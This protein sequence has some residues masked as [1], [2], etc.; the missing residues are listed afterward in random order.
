MKKKDKCLQFFQLLTLGL[1][2]H[3]AFVRSKAVTD[4]QAD[5]SQASS[6]VAQQ[7]IGDLGTLLDLHDNH[8]HHH[9]HEEHDPGFWKK[10]VIWKEGWFGTILM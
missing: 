4:Q 3:L 6:N 5:E 9:V 10:K 7:R 2:F 8:D 1:L